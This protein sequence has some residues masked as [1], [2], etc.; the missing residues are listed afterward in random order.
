MLFLN[1]LGL[2]PKDWIQ[3]VAFKY[4]TTPEAVRR[5][6]SRRKTWMK[7]ILKVE[8]ARALNELPSPHSKEG[9]KWPLKFMVIV[10]HNLKN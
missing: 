5:D 8:D 3:E 4:K 9:K 1:R 7:Q 10:T 2:K 6:W